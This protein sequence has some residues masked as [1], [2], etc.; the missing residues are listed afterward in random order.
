MTS[1]PE[2]V[3]A[4]F[5]LIEIIVVLVILGLMLSLAV[6]R[7]PM[8]SPALQVRAVAGELAATLRA[9]RGKAIA[10]NRPVAVV[11]DPAQRGFRVDGGQARLLPAGMQLAVTTLA[12][13]IQGNRL[14]GIVFAPDGS[15][16]GG[17]IDLADGPLR[18]QIGIDWL[19]GRVSVADAH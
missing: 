11:F 5:T 6:A 7:G 14:A 13:N 9:A 18:M 8:Q 2:P 15:S 4:G 10:A 1:R 12:G 3:A 16:S 19:T 17:L